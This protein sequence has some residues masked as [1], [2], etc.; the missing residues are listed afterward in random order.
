MKARLL[1]PTVLVSS[2]SLILLG[3]CSQPNKQ[4]WYGTW[5]NEKNVYQKSVHNPDGMVLNFIK[6]SDTTP[7]EQVKV[8]IVKCWSDSEGNVWLQTEG[9][10]IEG[11]HKN[12]IPKVQT[13]EKINKSGTFCEVMLRGVADF[14]PKSFPTKIDPIDPYLYMS[15]SRAAK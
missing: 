7:I 1:V 2:L 4:L 9:T 10:I 6:L 11:P 14:N 8:Q 15:F 13:L 5:T 12:S 3:G